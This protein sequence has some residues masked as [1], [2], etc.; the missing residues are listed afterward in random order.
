MTMSTIEADDDVSDSEADE[1]VKADAD[2]PGAPKR[3]CA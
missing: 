3:G 2:S 1:K